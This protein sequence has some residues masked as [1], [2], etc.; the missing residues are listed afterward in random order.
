MS[1]TELPP[2]AAAPALLQIQTWLNR[3]LVPWA[4]LLLGW[5]S[6]VMVSLGVAHVVALQEQKSELDAYLPW[7]ALL[8]GMVMAL[9]LFLYLRAILRT[10]QQA[11]RMAEAMTR[12]LRESEANQR[13]L[14]E[15]APDA[16]FV[17]DQQGR[18][19]DCNPAGASFFGYGHHELLGRSISILVPEPHHLAHD[20][21]L[22]R[23][24]ETGYSS[25]IGKGRDVTAMRKNGSLVSVHLRVSTQ[26]LPDGSIRF[27]GFVRDLTDRL[28]IEAELHQRQT[29]LHAIIDTTK[30]G[31]LVVDRM[32]H[33]LEVNDAYCHFS[34]Y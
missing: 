21:Y 32:G 1:E 25:V 28:R 26:R 31:Y 19:V 33:V 30:D 18:I 7:G 10:Q 2:S 13:A 16:I 29:E 4:V 8:V 17:L 11:S 34:G 24:L 23:Y 20:Q 27:L 22:K 3:T 12:E 6:S 14:V 15:F 9:L 5:V